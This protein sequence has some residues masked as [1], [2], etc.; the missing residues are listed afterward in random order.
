METPLDRVKEEIMK[1]LDLFKH[2]TSK[3]WGADRVSLLRLY[4]MLL[5][6]ML[7]YGVEIYSSCATTYMKQ[8]ET[9]QNSAV[10]IATGAFRSSPITSLY[11]DSGLRPLEYYQETKML[12]F[13]IRIGVNPNHPLRPLISRNDLPPKCCLGRSQ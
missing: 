7:D 6:P 11:A 12:N 5:K 13:F 2:L 3:R 4:I 1:T 8:I 10:R 9:I